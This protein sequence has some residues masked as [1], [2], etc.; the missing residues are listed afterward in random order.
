MK[1]LL[2]IFLCSAT[3]ASANHELEDRDLSSGQIL[4]TNN[5]ASCHGIKLEGQP[6]WRSPNA[7]GVLP[8]PP[9]DAK[10]HTWHHDNALLFNYTKLGGAGAL[11]AMDIADFN[12]GMPSFDGIIP[13]EEIWDIIAFIRSTWP[14]RE[15]KFQK[16]LNPT[17]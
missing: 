1:W 6:N 9:H 7:I 13:D 17:H 14:E 12:S 2:L 4:Y 3:I 15:R 5:C 10:G 16:N 11:A 8:A